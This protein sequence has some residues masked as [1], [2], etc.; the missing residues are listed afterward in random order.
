MKIIHGHLAALLAISGLF[1]AAGLS[2]RGDGFPE[3][4]CNPSDSTKPGVYWYWLRNNI[5]KEGITKDLEA[6]KRVGIGRAYIGNV[7]ATP[8]GQGSV[9]MFSD[10]WWELTA[11]AIR[12]GGRLGVDI[13]VF[14]C[15]GWSQSGGPWV[16][17]EQSMRYLA[18]S[19]TK[20]SGPGKFSAVLPVPGQPFT[21][22][23]VL[24]VP[25]APQDPAEAILRKST[26]TTSPSA[27]G[28]ALLDGD[29]STVCAFP[30]GAGVKQPFIVEI[31]CPEEVTVRNITIVPDKVQLKADCELQYKD[32]SGQYQ[33]V[34][35]FTMERLN[36]ANIGPM[37][38]GPVVEAFSAVKASEFRLVFTGLLTGA[39]AA[40]QKPGIAEIMLYESPRLERYVEKQM[41]QMFPTPHAPWDAYLWEP[42]AGSNEDAPRVSQIQNISASM[43]SSGKLIWDIPAGDWTILRVGMTPTGVQNNSSPKEGRGMETDK[44]NATH[45]N[46]H[47][48]AYLGKL[49]DRLSPEERKGWKYVVADSYEMGPQNWTDNLQDGF[50]S[51][52]HYDPLPWLPVLTGRVV[53]N[54]DQSDRFLWDLRRLVADKVASDY[55]KPLR[56]AA[57]ERGLKLWMENYGH[58]GFPGEDLQYGGQADEVAGEFWASGGLGSFEVRIASSSSHIYGKPIVSAESFT[59]GGTPWTQTPWS[60]KQ[61][62]DWAMAEGIN[63]FIL[64]LFIHQSDERAPGINAWFG[65]EFNRH[66]TWFD[67]MDGWIA[68]LRRAQAVLQQGHYVADLAYF[69]GEDAPKETGILDPALPPG[70][71]Y[72]FMNGEVLMRDLHV[73]DGRFVLPDGMEYRLLVLPPLEIMR[74]ELL[75]K[76][77]DLVRDGGAVLGE[78]P[79]RSPSMENYPA[80]DEQVRKLASGLW[81]GID[82]KKITSGRYGKGFVF[83][84][85]DAAEALKVIGVSPDIEGI[86]ERASFGKGD[87]FAW[88]HRRADDADVYFLSN[89]SDEKKSISLSFRANEGAPE[90]WDPVTG[91][92][93]ALPQF[94]REAGR[95]RVPLE[96]LPQQS[97]LVAF[98]KPGS[99]PAPTGRNNF[100]AF[101]TALRLDPAWDVTF[102]P[103]WGG[104]GTVR[105]DQLADWTIRAEEGIKYY[106]GTA[107]YR[108]AF[109]FEQPVSGRYFLNLGD[110]NSIARVK[111]N[112]MDIGVVWCHPGRIEITNALKT[113]VNELEIDVANTWNNRL[114]GD[115]KL[116]VQQRTT[117]TSMEVE[118][119]SNAQLLPSGLTGPVTLEKL[120]QPQQ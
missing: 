65:T 48:D 82:G 88:I 19:E 26:V 81:H 20:V 16:K 95:V 6:M 120:Q 94:T 35:K 111:L 75:Q 58:F 5:S 86:G 69:T 54:P 3:A 27:D 45:V 25:E 44:M 12:E 102:D 109:N 113:G 43:D 39:K 30:A 106:S 72:D 89:Q 61:R 15:P 112:G 36:K 11:H 57:H 108:S 70:Y 117:W 80:C 41:G 10:E 37:L 59:F 100:P 42:Q 116:P 47:F 14:N 76:I 51:R 103:K 13:G 107:V 67:Y 66:N 78:P 29:L 87:G 4:F 50:R 119:K 1:N 9:K 99:L 68:S 91:E 24:A 83:R 97:Y 115:S 92:M 101:E 17:P 49:V 64:H 46:A 55:A 28:A 62:G 84:G 32:S 114:L 2:A 118:M 56:E 8:I 40:N 52:Y 7:D 60:L 105:F 85:T 104:P 71:D 79:S 21:D 73:K 63:L 96:F 38:F 18:V 23:A 93:C 98:R 22:V 31:K 110:Y 53:N 90:L 77:S 74:P 33:Q 34:K